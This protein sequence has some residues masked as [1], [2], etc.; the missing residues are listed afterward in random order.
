M[1]NHGTV[2]SHSYLGRVRSRAKLLCVC[3]CFCDLRVEYVSLQGILSGVM[4]M[5]MAAD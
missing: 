1:Y 2:P 3:E 4:I 5:Y